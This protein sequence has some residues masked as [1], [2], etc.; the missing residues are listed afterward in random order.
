MTGIRIDSLGLEARFVNPLA[1]G[2]IVTLEQVAS[3]TV[4]RL[5]S[6]LGVGPATVQVLRHAIE[7]HG[8]PH[9][10]P[11]RSFTKRYD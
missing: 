4:E 6:Y 3:M 7:R 11:M 2:G 5:I 1:R 10:L 9:Q 8:I